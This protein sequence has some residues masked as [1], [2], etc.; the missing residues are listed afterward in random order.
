MTTKAYEKAEDRAT[1]H[2]K[3]LLANPTETLRYSPVDKED[4]LAVG[5][6]LI[7]LADA[8]RLYEVKKQEGFRGFEIRLVD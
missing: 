2:V 8:N 6:I 7:Q 1:N 5:I 4:L 3:W